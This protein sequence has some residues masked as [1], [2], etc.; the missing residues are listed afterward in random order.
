VQVVIIEKPPLRHIMSIPGRA[1][2]RLAVRHR[3]G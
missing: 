1:G 3:N 2:V